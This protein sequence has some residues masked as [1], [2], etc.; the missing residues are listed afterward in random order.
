[1]KSLDPRITRYVTM[2]ICAILAAVFVYAGVDKIRDPQ[3]FADSVAAFG[4][5]PKLLVTPF[6]LGLPV[7][8]VLC[9]LMLLVGRSRRVAAFAVVL[10]TAM[11][12]VALGTAL[13]RGLTLDCGCFGT[14]APSRSRMWLESV[15]DIVLLG[16]TL[17]VYIDSASSAARGTASEDSNH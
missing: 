13:A 4:M 1:M 15:L 8:E 12:F 11:F 16:A 2:G 3:S 7:L 5:V 14:G 6:A 9:G 10:L 17:F